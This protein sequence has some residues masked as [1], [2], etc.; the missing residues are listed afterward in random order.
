MVRLGDRFPEGGKAE[1]VTRQLVPGQVLY[2]FCQFTHPPKEKYLVLVSVEPGP[3]LFVV[4][5]R[6]SPFIADRPDLS[7]CQVMLAASDY[8]FL[9]HD[10]FIDCSRAISLPEDEITSQ[11]IADLGR[12][13]GTLSPTTRQQ[14]T[15]VVQAA[16]TISPAHK[17][18][19]ELALAPGDVAVSGQ[20]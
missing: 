18:A 2:L 16:Q 14:I 20:D 15:R 3:L 17:R 9:D 12:M 4:N 6:V 11:L 1:H 7:K 10:S 8:A 19:I 13:R 5:S